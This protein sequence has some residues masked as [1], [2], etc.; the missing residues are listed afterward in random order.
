MIECSR[1]SYGGSPCR[2][3]MPRSLRL[4]E[5]STYVTPYRAGTKIEEE[6]IGEVGCWWDSLNGYN[7]SPSQ[8]KYIQPARGCAFGMAGGL[9]AMGSTRLRATGR[10]TVRQSV[11]AES[12][13]L[14]QAGRQRLWVCSR[15]GDGRHGRGTAGGTPWLSPLPSWPPSR[16]ALHAP[17]VGTR[18]RSA[19]STRAV[20]PLLFLSQ[21]PSLQCPLRR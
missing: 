15:R 19:Q 8:E 21:K 10:P 12:P 7:Y 16:A 11:R 13:A 1:S 3:V 5:P 17:D 4:L 2:L 14:N 6:R 9:G 18:R 20:R